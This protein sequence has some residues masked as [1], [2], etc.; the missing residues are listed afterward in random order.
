MLAEALL[1]KF[2]VTAPEL[3]ARGLVLE[4]PRRDVVL[5]AQFSD[6]YAKVFVIV[7]TVVSGACPCY[8]SALPSHE[9]VKRLATIATEYVVVKQGMCVEWGKHA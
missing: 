9:T 8:S 5:M 2:I 7:L 6:L 3:M 4:D 1:N